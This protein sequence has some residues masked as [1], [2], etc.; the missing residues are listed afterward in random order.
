MIRNISKY[1]AIIIALMVVLLMAGITISQRMVT[2]SF[3]DLRL[4]P[5]L[6][7]QINDANETLSQIDAFKPLNGTKDGSHIINKHI[8]LDGLGPG[9]EEEV[10]WSYI[11]EKETDSLR[12]RWKTEPSTVYDDAGQLKWDT[13]ILATLLEYDHWDP[14]SSGPYAQ[15]LSLPPS[16][17]LAV[18]P[19]PNLI[20]LQYLAKARMAKGL[21][22]QNILPA[23]NEVRHLARLTLA[24]ENI[25]DSMIAL[26]LLNIER[27]G[28]EQAVLDGIIA[29]SDWTPVTEEEIKLARATIWA[30]I[31]LFAWNQKDIATH[32]HVLERCTILNE[33][34]FRMTHL[35]DRAAFPR[36]PFEYDIFS[37]FEQFERNWKESGCPLKQIELYW[38]KG[39]NVD[40]GNSAEQLMFKLPYFRMVTFSILAEMGHGLYYDETHLIPE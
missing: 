8:P 24:H 18:S 10:W 12:T 13:S 40:D 19:I 6:I 31:D 23:L 7:E 39:L 11:D 9:P 32:P 36:W 38:G 3:E 20:G 1:S 33:V 29:E 15:I 14:S 28:Y 34:G 5:A 17:G 21:H 37:H 25:V 30:S 26:A 35:Q 27:N 16:V 22:D 4:N 2:A